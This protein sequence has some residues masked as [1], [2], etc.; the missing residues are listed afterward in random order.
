MHTEPTAA[1]N[2]TRL[3]TTH[4]QR[5][6]LDAREARNLLAV[7]AGASNAERLFCELLHYSGARISEALAVMPE[8]IDASAHLIVFRTLKRRRIVHRAVP[9]PARL[10]RELASL[11]VD[12]APGAPVFAW[13]RAHGWRVITRLMERA[14]ISGP[15]ACPRGLRHHFGVN[16]ISHRVPESM[17]QR[18]MGHASRKSTSIY[19]FAMGREERA[20]A[21]RMWKGERM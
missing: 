8:H 2:E 5:K 18:W 12:T 3:F 6:Y 14:G 10:T 1:I 7:A 17:L 9:V 13:S 15:Q 4:G 16:A 21:A 20:V 19:T 11:A